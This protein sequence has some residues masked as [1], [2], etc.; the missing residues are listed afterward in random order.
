MRTKT[1]E[2]QSVLTL[3]LEVR[4]YSAKGVEVSLKELARRWLVG[5]DEWVS[6]EMKGGKCVCVGRGGAIFLAVITI[7]CYAARTSCPDLSSLRSQSYI[8][9]AQDYERRA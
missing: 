2:L 5:R 9:S 4:R 3:D 1:G 7:P 6:A 8:I